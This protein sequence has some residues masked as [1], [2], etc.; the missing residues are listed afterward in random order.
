MPN[1]YTLKNL[2]E[3]A[4]AAPDL[5]VAE[6]QEVR[7]ARADFDAEH[8]GFTL[9]RVSPGRRQAIGHKHHHP[10]AEEVYVVIAG[11][12]R[13][14]LDDETFEIAPLDAIRVEPEVIRSFEGGP[15]GIEFLAFGPRHDG[16]GEVFPG[17][18]SD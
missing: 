6:T 2:N 1:P 13:I 17:W 11:A 5:G 9:H 10:H 7:F 4:D 12:G 14:K 15:D 3:V 16:D 18:W 8:V